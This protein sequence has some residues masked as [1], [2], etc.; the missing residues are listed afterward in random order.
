MPVRDPAEFHPRQESSVSVW[1]VIALVAIAAAGAAWW[2]GWRHTQAPEP[3]PAAP[4][5][6]AAPPAAAPQVPAS[7]PQNPV[8]VLEPPADALPAL[9]DSD[10]YVA[11]ALAELLGPQAAALLQPEGLVR[12]MVATID[13]LARA[14]APSRMWPVQATPGRFTVEGAQDAPAQTIAPANAARY[15]AFVTLAEDVPVDAAVKLY[16]RMY[17]LF[18]AA[19]EELGFPGR[20]FNDRLVAVLDHLRAAPEPAGPLQVRL[21]PVVGEVPSTRPW[22]RYEFVDPQLQALSSGQKMLVRMGPENARRLKAV[23]AELRRRVA[24][25]DMAAGNVARIPAQATPPASR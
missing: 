12:R 3:A 4:A 8:E 2:F 16:A 6:E 10:A 23:L 11:R 22:V 13:N 15:Q 14:Q 21:V 25:G 24:T 5:V 9:A 18:Q 17:P 19:Y 20:Y 7:G 1:T